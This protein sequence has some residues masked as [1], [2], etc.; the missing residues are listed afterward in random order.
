VHHSIAFLDIPNHDSWIEPHRPLDLW[1]LGVLCREPGLTVDRVIV[2]PVGE[3][4][5]ETRLR[6]PEIHLERAAVGF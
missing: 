2:E 6:S 1:W 5:I 3:M 4:E